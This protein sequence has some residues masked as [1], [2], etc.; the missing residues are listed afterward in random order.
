MRARNNRCENLEKDITVQRK[1]VLKSTKWAK[2][3]SITERGG[4]GG[5][6]GKR[7]RVSEGKKGRLEVSK[8]SKI[9]MEVIR[10]VGGI[11][12]SASRS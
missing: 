2:K 1:D 8:R 12:R 3:R 7:K 6:N 10:R 5:N 4:R 9:K 11:Q